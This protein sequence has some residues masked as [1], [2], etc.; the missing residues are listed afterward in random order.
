MENRVLRHSLYVSR[1]MSKNL[2]FESSCSDLLMLLDYHI[3]KLLKK[4]TVKYSENSVFFQPVEP[5]DMAI[6]LIL[7]RT[8]NKSAEM[9]AEFCNYSLIAFTINIGV[10]PQ[11]SFSFSSHRDS[12]ISRTESTSEKPSFISCSRSQPGRFM[13]LSG[14][15]S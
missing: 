9:E 14:N 8:L 15:R 3:E 10:A 7:D 11:S 12:V 2:F 6:P 5:I 4:S 1:K 13:E